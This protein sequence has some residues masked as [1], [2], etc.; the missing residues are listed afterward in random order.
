MQVPLP[1]TLNLLPEAPFPT[2]RDEA[3]L[4]QVCRARAFTNGCSQE[5]Q[6]NRTTPLHESDGDNN[7]CKGL[8][9][10]SEK[11]AALH[12]FLFRSGSLDPDY[13]PKIQN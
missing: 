4:Q 5:L 11:V 3:H 9:M 10:S 2:F 13:R 1:D 7:E 12:R 6:G 8:R